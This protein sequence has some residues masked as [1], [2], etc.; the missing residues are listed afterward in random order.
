MT[1]RKA[2]AN[3][4]GCP[5][6]GESLTRRTSEMVHPLLQRIYLVCRNAVCGATFAATSEITHR[7][8]PPSC[9][10]PAVRLPY[11]D[12]TTRASILKAQGMA[13]EPNGH[14]EEN[15]ARIN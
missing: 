15:D 11:A 13:T 1:R 14:Q 8:S 9:P 12:R 4:Y 2:P 10:N 3:R 6:C 7:L 5:D